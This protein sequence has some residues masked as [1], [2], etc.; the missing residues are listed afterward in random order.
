ML[1]IVS[2]PIGNLEDITLRALRILKEVDLIACEDTRHTKILLDHYGIK[3]PLVSF[4]QHSRLTKI[5][6]LIRL[7]AEGKN[8]ALVTDAG[9]PGI[10]DPAGVLI[11]KIEEFNKKLTTANQQPIIISP[12]P[13]PSA[14]TAALSVCGF[15]VDRLLFLGF[16]PKKKGRE[17]LLKSL[18]LYGAITI[19][20]YES[21]Y[22]LLKTLRDLQTVLGDCPIVICREMTKKFEEIKRN[23]ISEIIEYYSKKKPKGEFTIVIKP[24]KKY[25]R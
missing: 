4:H 18:P 11:A 7:L 1:Y 19:V 25:A 2:T 21:P 8:I 6:Y 20:L 14:L 16:L 15:P 10:S 12:I 23:K 13:G 5:D 17:K 9:T 24:D 22:R 3:K